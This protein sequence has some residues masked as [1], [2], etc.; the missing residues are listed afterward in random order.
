MLRNMGVLLRGSVVAMGPD[1]ID[2]VAF[3]DIAEKLFKDYSIPR[4][5]RPI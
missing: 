4:H 3:F 5:F 1:Q 2:A